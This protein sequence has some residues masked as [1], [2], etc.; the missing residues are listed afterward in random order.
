[1]AN[2]AIVAYAREI[3]AELLVPDEHGEVKGGEDF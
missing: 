2:F 1:M 3:A